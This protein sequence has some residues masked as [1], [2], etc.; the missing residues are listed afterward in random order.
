MAP[1]P[2]FLPFAFGFQLPPTSDQ[3]RCHRANPELVFGQ[4]SGGSG[5]KGSYVLVLHVGQDRRLDVGK[6]GSFEFPAGY[7]LYFGSALNDLEGR[8]RRHLRREKKLHWHIDFLT[9]AATVVQVWWVAE[10]ERSECVWAWAALAHPGVGV[11]VG[12]FG[13][14]DCRCPAHLVRLSSWAEA[15]ALRDRLIPATSPG[16]VLHPQQEDFTLAPLS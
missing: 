5:V 2:E 11:P 6:L 16:G 7:Y 9:A 3:P 15:E 14:S 1:Q 8:I 10:E 12:R 13:S 4:S